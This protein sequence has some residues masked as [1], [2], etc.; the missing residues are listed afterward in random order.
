MAITEIARDWGTNPAI[1]RITSTDGLGTVLGSTYLTDQATTIAELNNGAFQWKAGD[2]I[3]VHHAGGIALL[4][5]DD[6]NLKITNSNFAIPQIAT[7]QITSAE[8]LALAAANKTLVAAPGAGLVNQFV[9]LA[10]YEDFNTT[11]YTIANAGDDLAVRHGVGG[12]IC[13]ETIQAQGFLDETEDAYATGNAITISAE[14]S[15]IANTALV[16]DNIGAAEYTLGNSPV[17]AI[18]EY[19]TVVVPF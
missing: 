10:M 16:L 3:L 5:Y 1:V 4:S 9:S 15:D 17:T 18:V 8:I 6:T 11:A 13:S 19:R 12:P 14:L 2:A 7:V